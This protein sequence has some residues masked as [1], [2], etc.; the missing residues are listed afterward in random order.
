MANR[1]TTSRERKQQKYRSKRRLAALSFLTNISLDGSYSIKA[2]PTACKSKQ[3]SKVDDN[4]KACRSTRHTDDGDV[5]GDANIYGHGDDGKSCQRKQETSHDV[6]SEDRK[7]NNF[8]GLLN[9][10]VNKDSD[11]FKKHSIGG[12][13]SPKAFKIERFI[14]GGNKRW[15]YMNESL[16]IV[17]MHSFY[18]HKS[19]LYK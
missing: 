10:D 8:L 14:D 1:L 11:G 2:T 19:H 15:R 7:R 3:D 4:N 16:P 13:R 6:D 5:E 9:E 12:A 17:S 18:F